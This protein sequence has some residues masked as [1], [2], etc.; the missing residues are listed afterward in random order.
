MTPK[1]GL[2]DLDKVPELDGVPITQVDLESLE[3]K[4]WRKPGADITDYF[5]YGFDEFSWTSYCLRQD[6]LRDDYDSNKLM[7]VC[8]FFFL[9]FPF[10]LL[11]INT[12]IAYDATNATDPTTA[13]DNALPSSTTSRS[14]CLLAPITVA[15][16]FYTTAIWSPAATAV[17]TTTAAA[18]AADRTSGRP[19]RRWTTG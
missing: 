12:D 4:P 2:V 11:Y 9:F 16:I 13:N 5:N 3:D 7:A 6:K 14:L 18:T 1:A 17:S 8:G 19:I 10:L 15:F